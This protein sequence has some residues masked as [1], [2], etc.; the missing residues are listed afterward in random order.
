MTTEAPTPLRE[1]V[2]DV[3]HAGDLAERR[4]AAVAEAVADATTRC[5][6]PTRPAA[7]GLRRYGE[8]CLVVAL[9]GRFDRPA[10]ERLRALGPEIERR[11]TT[12]LV[13]DLSRLERCDAL[14]ARAIARIRIRCLAAQTRVELHDPP[15]ALAAELGRF[16]L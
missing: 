5:G 2:L 9:A 12:E 4:R 15:P 16:R 3:E 10:V 1:P 11:A 14:L 13:V 6:R 8:G 7:A